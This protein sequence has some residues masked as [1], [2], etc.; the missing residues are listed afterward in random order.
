MSCT[1]IAVLLLPART[2][3]V[4]HAAQRHTVSGCVL[5]SAGVS[6]PCFRCGGVCPFLRSSSTV[7]VHAPLA[8]WSPDQAVQLQRM[9][10]HNLSVLGFLNGHAGELQQEQAYGTP[11]LTVSL[12]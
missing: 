7:S 11:F 9:G 4:G 12:I 1:R 5:C 3:S 2:R 6:A 10:L 8:M